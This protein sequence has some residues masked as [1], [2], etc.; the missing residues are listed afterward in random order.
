MASIALL[1]GARSAL[2]IDDDP[3]AAGLTFAGPAL[4][5]GSLFSAGTGQIP[6]PDHRRMN[7]DV[8]MG[9]YIPIDGAED[10]DVGA[11]V[12]L[13]LEGEVVRFLFL[14]GEF[15]YAGHSK[16]SG[17]LLSDGTMHRFFFLVPI[18]VDLPFAGDPENP[19]SVRFGVAPGLQLAVPVVDP[20]LDDLLRLNSFRLK[21]ESAVA[22]DV[23]ARI[24]LRLPLDPHFG[25]IIA[26]AYDY[27]EAKMRARLD[28]L[29]TGAVD[30][31]KKWVN[32]SGVS[33]LLGFEFVF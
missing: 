30:R 27:A 12:D 11:T 9:P 26:A 32:L 14:G 21:E 28:D 4:P 1:W 29:L 6:I 23:R 5:L 7:F 20:D 22:F 33:V 16:N 10:F 3:A 17:R 18:E 15:A 31:E 13:L 2:G 8:S 25:F 19:F 24:T